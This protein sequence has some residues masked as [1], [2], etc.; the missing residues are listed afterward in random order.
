M[1]I[2]R[3]NRDQHAT[4]IATLPPPAVS[5]GQKLTATSDVLNYNDILSTMETDTSGKGPVLAAEEEEQPEYYQMEPQY[6]PPMR[7]MTVA[8]LPPPAPR[9][10]EQPSL[11]A[12]YK[13]PLFVTVLVGLL[14]FFLVPRLENWLPAAFSEGQLNVIGIALISAVTG[15]T[16]EIGDRFILSKF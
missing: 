15:V 8:D 3:V 11:L 5:S 12:Q 4:P 2:E 13:Y 16:F 1:S 7:P 9:V 6:E 14:L 10:V